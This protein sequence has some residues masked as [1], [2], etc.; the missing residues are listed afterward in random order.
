MLNIE[1]LYQ[2]Y[3]IP[4]LSDRELIYFSKIIK[5]VQHHGKENIL[6][7]LLQRKSGYVL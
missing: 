4:L 7:G 1:H 3:K 6:R 2:Y 5:N